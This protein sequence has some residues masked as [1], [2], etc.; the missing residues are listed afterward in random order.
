MR[1]KLPYRALLA[2][3]LFAC[4]CATQAASTTFGSTDA[5]KCYQ[6]SLFRFSNQ[7]VSYCNDA[8][9][10]GELNRRDLAATYSNRGIIHLKNG[11]YEKALKDHDR[12]VRIK[13]DMPQV[14]I[15]RGNVL[16]HTHDYEEALIEFD[17]AIET[18]HG[19]VAISLFNKA[20][21]LLKLRRITEAKTTLE[22]ALEADPQSKRIKDKL[23]DIASLSESP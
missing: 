1:F 8:I 9:N 11:K 20:L 21:T 17:K 3:T 7:G 12:A 15:N 16:Y 23:E 4:T 6:E 14:H 18:D 10:R 2:L 13:P 22:F 19:L 5:V